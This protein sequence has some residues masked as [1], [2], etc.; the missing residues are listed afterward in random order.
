MIRSA[1]DLADACLQDNFQRKKLIVL[2]TQPQASAAIRAP[3]VQ[4]PE[5]RNCL[6]FESEDVSVRVI[7]I[8]LAY[9]LCPPPSFDL[10]VQYS[11]ERM[12]LSRNIAR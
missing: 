1:A 12:H 6:E 9:R 5:R 10:E 7:Y 4:L 8:R 3:S 11:V 2:S